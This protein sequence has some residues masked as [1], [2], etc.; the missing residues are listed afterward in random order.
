MKK[1]S[2][3]SSI[4]H[5]MYSTSESLICHVYF[6][7]LFT[8]GNLH[9]CNQF[10]YTCDRP[11]W[12]PIPYWPV[13]P[14]V[15]LLSSVHNALLGQPKSKN[16]AGKKVRR[17]SEIVLPNIKLNLREVRSKFKPIIRT[18]STYYRQKGRTALQIQLGISKCQ[19]F[20]QT[21]KLLHPVSFYLN[22]YIICCI[23]VAVKRAMLF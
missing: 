1:V 5:F 3:S 4:L 22:S 6:S 9:T 18:I 15:K 7:F 8:N 23:L 12:A 17:T 10:V 19:H 14:F 20:L 2:I 16:R 11:R 21:D 13:D